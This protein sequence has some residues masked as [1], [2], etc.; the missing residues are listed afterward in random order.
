[1]RPRP[2]ETGST[3]PPPSR[4]GFSVSRNS[5]GKR[6][7][8]QGGGPSGRSKEIV[9]L[10]V[11]ELGDQL[12]ADDE[13]AGGLG[14]AVDD[15]RRQLVALGSGTLELDDDEPADGDATAQL[16]ADAG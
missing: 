16:E 3:R 1:M 9:E 7:F 12:A 4:P 11:R 14:R 15:T 13:I 8:C 2:W 5:G 10:V 6:R